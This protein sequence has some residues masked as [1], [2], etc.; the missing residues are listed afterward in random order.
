MPAS[1]V[2]FDASVL[3]AASYSA[4]GH[5]RDLVL[6]AIQG[7]IQAMVSQDVLDEVQRNMIRKAPERVEAYIELLEL[8]NLEIV[9]D[10]SAEE[11]WAVE[12]YVVQKDAPIVAAAINAQPDYLV[13]FDRK[14]L[15]D[16]PEVAE[17]SDLMIVV[18]EVVVIALRDDD[19][20]PN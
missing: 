11:V 9:A 1:R 4:S 13:T 6:M 14:H 17:K 18:P 3:F 7:R 10:P 12:A 8:M 5:A 2:F 19:P 16:P 20:S 15:I